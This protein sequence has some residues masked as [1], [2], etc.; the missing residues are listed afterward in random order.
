MTSR[1]PFIA[2]N[3]KMFK[4]YSQS[5]ASAIRLKES[6][7]DVTGVDVMIAPQYTAIIPVVNAIKE[8]QI[9]IGAQN[10]HWEKEGPYTGE[11]SAPM[12]IDSGCQYVIIGHSERRQFFGENN[13]SVCK[14][15]SSALSHGLCPVMCIG[16]S[17]EERETN[18]T[19]SVLDKQIQ[20]GLVDIASDKINKLIVAY[21]PV[22][23]IGTGKTA[24]SEQAQETHAFIR[25]LIRSK[26]G[27]R[28]G[29]SI[30]ILYGGS[31]KP[32][33]IAE[34]MSMPDIDG[35]LVGGASLDADTFARIVKFNP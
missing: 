19:N 26:F 3:W 13:A 4:T 11:V 23:A 27:E 22:W 17:E 20:K 29:D 31:V 25:N 1:K 35:A 30:R 15:I 28:L 33:N 5:V 7:A 8:S 10:L 34:L 12:L 9:M 24:T 14:K 21:E 6:I 2:G 32:D 18:K 16:E